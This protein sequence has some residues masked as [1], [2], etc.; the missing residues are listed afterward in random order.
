MRALRPARARRLDEVG[1]PALTAALA[2]HRASVELAKAARGQGDASE[3]SA[4]ARDRI[5]S[6][7]KAIASSDDARFA[8]RLLR[9]AMPADALEVGPSAS[10]FRVPGRE[11]VS[12]TSRPTLAR[13]L[14]A[15]VEAR[16]G[17]PGAPLPWDDL[18][19]AGWP[20]ER[21]MPSAAQ[22]RVRV[23][24]STLRTLGLRTLLVTENGGH[25]LS[26][27]VST[28]RL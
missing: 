25:R 6:E 3:V 14:D 19:A 10:W 7:E 15:L 9:R 1:D 5:A 8:L 17:R 24:L 13:L 23:A 26:E 2:F 28:R 4:R 21:V 12:L 18:L 11:T 27:T 22:N 20:D 16:I